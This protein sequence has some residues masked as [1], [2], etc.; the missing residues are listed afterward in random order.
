MKTAIQLVERGLVPRPLIR[1]GI[2]RLLGERLAELHRTW[3][4]D[5]E[6][7]RSAWLRHMQEAP[8]ALVPE[9]ANEQ[10]YEV[11][12]EFYAQVLGP[13][14]KYS[15]AWYETGR[16]TLAEAEAAMLKLTCERAGLQDGQ[17]VLEMG[18]GWGSL[19]LYMAAHFPGSRIL[20]VSN[21]NS[22]RE[23]ILA[24]AAERGLRNIEVVT[25]DM[26]DFQAPGH[27]DRVVSV[28]MWEHMRNWKR[29]LG[30]VESWLKPG[31]KL[32]LHVFAHKSYAYPFE[33]R[34]PN[35]WMSQYF[36][37]GGMMPSHDLLDHVGG[38]LRVEQRW[39]VSGRHYA[40]TSEDWARNMDR[41][42]ETI[43]PILAKAYGSGAERMWFHRWRVFFLACAELF[44]WNGG[45]EWIVS[46]NLL[47]REGS[48][49][50]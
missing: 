31:G 12:A 42:R 36:F 44:A 50:R 47:S 30:R 16:E 27:Y 48:A 23:Y 32:F 15:S 46:H 2:R 4:P 22:Q 43:L 11:P 13:H 34:G 17:E 9:L 7:A 35:D 29:L 40:Q 25:C 49:V 45:E 39:A 28:E 14:R 19:T 24:Q 38:P 3:D 20:A 1:R 21:S 18:C 26:N 5:P 6:A 10:H 8:I 37:T 33:V 41:R